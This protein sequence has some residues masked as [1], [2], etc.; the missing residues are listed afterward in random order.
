ME[1]NENK[2]K[3]IRYECKLRNC[4]DKRSSRSQVLY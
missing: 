3:T 1:E 4:P 2:S